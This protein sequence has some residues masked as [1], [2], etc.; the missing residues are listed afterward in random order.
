[1]LRLLV[2]RAHLTLHHIIGVR[3]RRIFWNKGSRAAVPAGGIVRDTKHRPSSSWLAFGCRPKSNARHTAAV[4]TPLFKRGLFRKKR[5]PKRRTTTLMLHIAPSK[6]SLPTCPPLYPL[7]TSQDNH[8]SASHSLGRSCTR[9]SY[10]RTVQRTVGCHWNRQGSQEVR[11]VPVH[12]AIPRGPP[13][14][15][16]KSELIWMPPVDSL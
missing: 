16:W 4:A 12:R 10:Q 5:F 6:R 1:V 13:L 15:L 2:R 8:R 14:V 11:P 7:R 9:R 3:E